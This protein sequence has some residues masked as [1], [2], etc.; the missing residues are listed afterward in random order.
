MFRLIANKI[1]TK[2][3]LGTTQAIIRIILKNLTLIFGKI[4]LL[5][6]IRLYVVCYSGIEPNEFDFHY[7]SVKSLCGISNELSHKSISNNL[8]NRLRA[9]SDETVDGNVLGCARMPETKTDLLV[10]LPNQSVLDSL[11]QNLIV[12]PLHEY[13]GDND[14]LKDLHQELRELF[15]A[16]I[17]TPF[18]FV[19]S[20]MWTTRPSSDR[21]G[22][23]HPHRD[24]FEGGHPI[25][26]FSA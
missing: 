19:T 15:H 8:L 4:K 13:S 26:I 23:N 3:I 24:C 7:Q 20:R 14:I 25:K 18:V 2:G 5:S 9:F 1:R 21:Y 11:N 22:H 17:K 12:H 6:K 10:E 16:D